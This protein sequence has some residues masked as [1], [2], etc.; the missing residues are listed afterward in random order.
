MAYDVR[1][2]KDGFIDP[3]YLGYFRLFAE[4]KF[5]EAHEV[6]EVLWLETKGEDRDFYQG[7]I[8]LAAS[9]VHFQK[10][11]LT[12]AKELFQTAS[13]YLESFKPFHE[14]VEV[15]QTLED[16]RHFLEVWSKNPGNPSV[17]K[18]CLPHVILKEDIL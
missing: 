16:F 11:N 14:G 15:S 12:G 13:K 9:L 17:A 8:Q 7:L 6:L 2:T 5:F 4:E 18:E 1:C 3:R 10:G